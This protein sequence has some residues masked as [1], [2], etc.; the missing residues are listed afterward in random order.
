MQRL[1]L[2]VDDLVK[3]HEA[4]ES[5]KK[6]AESYGCA[7]NVVVKRLNEAGV[8]QRGRSEAMYVR[9]RN[10]SPEERLRLTEKAHEAARGRVCSEEQKIKGA[11][12]RFLRQRG[13]SPYAVELAHRLEELGAFSVFEYPAGPYNLDLS[14]VGTTVAV[15]VHGG[16]WHTSGR[17]GR[18]RGDRLK[19][20]LSRGWTVIEVWQVSKS[21]NSISVANQVV[22]IAQQLGSDPAT[23]GQHWMLRCDGDLAPALRSYG[24]NVPAVDS[25]S[26]RRNTTGQYLRAA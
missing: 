19:Y 14:L 5:V 3:R 11:R 26:R 13:I 22:A 15:E 17:H 21:W 8:S 2:D 6:I 20:L 25:A 23:R 18:R 10:A 24:H 12:T 16:G 7:R 9:M 1:S 4:G